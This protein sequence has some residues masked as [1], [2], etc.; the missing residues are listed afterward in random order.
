LISDSP[1][2]KVCPPKRSILLKLQSHELDLL[3]FRNILVFKDSLNYTQLVKKLL[4]I[5]FA[6]EFENINSKI[7]RFNIDRG[8]LA[9]T[10][11]LCSSSS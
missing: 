10:G 9:R 2:T 5:E 4:R 3:I 8:L 11:F 7:I 1:G 6:F